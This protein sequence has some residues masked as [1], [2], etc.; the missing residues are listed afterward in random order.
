M[1]AGTHNE[2]GF[3]G[4]EY[5]DVTVSRELEPIYADGYENFGWKLEE[6]GI[7]LGKPTAV[8]MQ[9]K[10]DRKIRN[11]AELARLQRQFDAY[12]GEVMALRKEKERSA[13]A[14][15]YSIGII[16]TALMAGAVFTLQAGIIPVM[17]ILGILG[18]AGWTAPYFLYTRL[19]REKTIR[20]T[21]LIDAK[22][23]EIYSVC[24]KAND[25]LAHA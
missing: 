25:L 15:A 1:N 22:Y 4:Y 21:P 14:V 10:R 19:I 3:I 16:G 8:K 7:P 18:F 24:E 11:V 23:D 5:K 6:V 12:A 9:F 17:V 2:K 13:S 20:V